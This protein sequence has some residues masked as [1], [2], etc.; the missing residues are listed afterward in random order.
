MRVLDFW[1]DEVT[2]Y[3]NLKAKAVAAVASAEAQL[4]EAR[5]KQGLAVSAA[6]QAQK[7]ITALR[8]KMATDGP[9]DAAADALALRA[10]VAASRNAVGRALLHGGFAI[11]AQIALDRART[12]LDR[13]AHK[14]AA[15]SAA[16][17]EATRQNAIL[18]AW[19]ASPL[20]AVQSDAKDKLGGLNGSTERAAAKTVLDNHFP[21]LTCIVQPTMSARRTIFTQLQQHLADAA[22]TTR[23]AL[24]N[25]LSAASAGPDD[26]VRAAQINFDLAW[27]NL[28]R[29]VRT[30]REELERATALYA[31]VAAMPALPK[32]VADD[33]LT[34]STY[35]AEASDALADE[36]S[37]NA[38]LTDASAKR[39]KLD[40]DR[41]ADES[42]DPTSSS[43]TKTVTDD[44]ADVNSST[45]TL[46]SKDADFVAAG[47]KKAKLDAWIAALTD[48][49]IRA[50]LAMQE[51]DEIVTRLSG[52]TASELVTAVTDADKGLAN[53]LFAAA[54][55]DRTVAYLE[56]ALA[57]RL[58]WLARAEQGR[59]DNLFSAVR[60]DR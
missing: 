41:I 14:L 59:L 40:T 1:N 54:R 34:T 46:A 49:A 21:A 55:A 23:T 18:T 3:T 22:E 32:P 20:A 33:I 28:A 30:A 35:G 53:A 42:D 50:V 37:R 8:I 52:I 9:A 38:A 19:V 5:S 44:I 7:H 31:S 17:D 47:G 56:D 57:Q 16:K 58:A 48:D 4:A 10:E 24:A 6:A 45:A 13:A 39:Y 15:A 51:A 26:A 36:Q 29:Y 2:A 60:G 12:E 25:R 11:E 27:N 43:V